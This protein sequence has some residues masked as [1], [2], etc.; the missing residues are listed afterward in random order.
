MHAVRTTVVLVAAV[1]AVAGAVAAAAITG[2]RAD[3]DDL[4][5][6]LAVAAYAAVGTAVELARPG[7]LV[8]RVMVCGAAAWGVGE[9]LLA[10]GVTELTVAGPSTAVALA[11]VLGTAGRGFGWLTL[12]L[13]L[14]LVFPDGRSPSRLATGLVVGAIA[15]FTVASLIAP[16]PLEERMS[17][18]RNPVGVPDS[19][20]TVADLVAVGSLLLAS[21]ALVVVIVA[22]F[23]RWRAGDDL[24]RQQLSVFGVA[25][26]LPLLVLPLAATSASMPWMYA[27]S[28]L[29]LPVA[30]A[31]AMFQRR[32]YDAQLAAT[33]TLTYVALSVVLAAVYAV[34]VVGVGVLLQDRGAPWLPLVGTAVVAV[35]FAPLR[36]WLQGLVNRITYG[37][38]AAP[39]AVLADTGRRLA[40]AADS[41]ALLE[42]LTGEMVAGLGIAS[43]AIHDADGQVL[44]A[45]GTSSSASSDGLPLTAYGRQ[46]GE[47]RWS[48]RTLR[49]ADRA[50]LEAVANQIGAAVYTAGIVDELRL[51][52]GQLVR[53]RE[54]E[55]RRLRSDLHDGLGPALAGLG[56]Q[57]DGVRNLIAD[58]KPVQDRLDRLRAGLAETVAEVRR[59]VEGLRPPAVDDLGVFGAIAELGRD[60]ADGSG[61]AVTLDLPDNRSALPAA[62]EVAAYRVTQEALTN[63]V[64][65]A[66]ASQCLVTGS[67][68]ESG[69]IIEIADN[70]HGGARPSTGLGIPGMHDRAAEIGGSLELSTHEAGTTVTLRLPLT[71]GVPS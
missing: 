23:R 61:V 4:V 64:R 70:G 28:T 20:Q 62:V 8:G 58:G 30:V 45:A 59:I 18:I 5:I 66:G 42:E 34:V 52:Q 21:A 26:A 3:F 35:A 12:V 17:D 51:A 48:G 14:P 43:A 53:A 50:L 13:A 49:P 19:W 60:L 69:L 27:V 40:D 9:G 7:H 29:P 10:W 47:L 24:V 46:V 56:F 57:L 38:W 39:A 31:V 2:S 65:H 55:R 36:D 15:S 25:F 32:L 1:L 68:S 37:R 44:A 54:Q 16:V 71:S 63:V 33:R 67:L 22:M 6:V 11:G 41:P